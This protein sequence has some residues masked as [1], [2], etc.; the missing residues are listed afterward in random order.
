MTPQTGSHPGNALTPHNILR[1]E[2]LRHARAAYRHAKESV[3]ADETPE[4]LKLAQASTPEAQEDDDD[5]KAALWLP[6]GTGAGAA[7]EAAA[8][9]EAGA[10]AS[11]AGTIGT[12]A[13]TGSALL[14]PSILGAFAMAAGAN[15]QDNGP[16]HNIS[17]RN[18]LS[19]GHDS[20]REDA[21]AGTEGQS[22]VA[23]PSTDTA[24][25]ATGTAPTA[26]SRPTNEGTQAEASRTPAV[27]DAAA[28][29]STEPAAPSA[30]DTPTADASKPAEGSDGNALPQ[31][32]PLP[33]YSE[34]ASV[35]YAHG[36]NKALGATVFSGSNDE[37]APAFVRI[38]AIQGKDGEA[39]AG[40]M[41]LL[42]GNA[43]VP[44][45][46]ISRAD[47]D[48]VVW[49]ASKN[50]GGSFSFVPVQDAQGTALPGALEQT[51]TIHEAPALP[52]YEADV[53][54]A[55][56]YNQSKTV[57]ADI[58]N[59]TDSTTAPSFVRITAIQGKEGEAAANT[60]SLKDGDALTAGSVIARADFDKVVWDASK[61][62][63]GSFKFIPV[64]DA[65]GTT[66]P[67]AV[68]QTVSINEARPLFHIPA[69]YFDVAGEHPAYVKVTNFT[70][71]N[72]TNGILD[73]LVLGEDGGTQ[74]KVGD[75]I[76]AE[77]FGRV[78]WNHASN[79]GGEI[80]LTP[81]NANDRMV[82]PGPY[83][84]ELEPSWKTPD[85]KSLPAPHHEQEATDASPEL[86]GVAHPATD[87]PMPLG[88]QAQYPGMTPLAMSSP[89]LLDSLLEQHPG[90][91]G[92]L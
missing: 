78:Y 52:T 21:N 11:T 2:V 28:A 40:T 7:T 25:L 54:V 41:S 91:T 77:D 19:T 27:A 61:N 20:S 13:A 36:E 44:N 14:G 8:M 65:Q 63:G 72:D 37:T 74:L 49:D 30:P 12:T 53:S 79:D 23:A 24:P 66:L 86:V 75:I 64:Q 57:G 58:F 67:G 70:E 32:K 38:T 81:Y 10:A 1:R 60:M 55:Y 22:S 31:V 17:A 9:T 84:M 50:E 73:A 59:G 42:G 88:A 69:G 5:D 39:A 34:N 76:R 82:D 87:G 33:A 15:L 35:S 56:T 43:I 51:V 48:K 83:S 62:E 6:S 45:Q 29:A 46:V 26:P 3:P 80:F 90:T 92:L 47:F 18:R 68:E 89:T 71:A 85:K 4:H 16:L